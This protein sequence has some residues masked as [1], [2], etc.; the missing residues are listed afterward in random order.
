MSEA[1]AGL[2]DLL[3]DGS[4]GLEFSDAATLLVGA[5]TVAEVAAQAG[6][7]LIALIGSDAQRLA[8]ALDVIG[9]AAGDGTLTPAGAVALMVGIAAAGT[10]SQQAT[11]GAAL[12][13]LVQAGTIDLGTVT[14]RL[15]A[16]VAGREH[17]RRRRRVRRDAVARTTPASIGQVV[18]FINYLLGQEALSASDATGA[19][20]AAGT[21]ATPPSRRAPPSTC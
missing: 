1:T 8:D 4:A 14:G 3:A 6:A 20:V 13:D 10:Q 5:A 21:E 16:E 18:S 17:G 7:G 15:T 11:V 19:I 9:A 2:A 12:D